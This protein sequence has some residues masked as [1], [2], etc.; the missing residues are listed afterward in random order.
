MKPKVIAEPATGDLPSVSVNWDADEYSLTCSIA[1]SDRETSMEVKT[2]S[3][4]LDRQFNICPR[5]YVMTGGS[6]SMALD[7]QLRAED[8]D[9]FTNPAQWIDCSFPYVDA[10]VSKLTFCADFDSNNRAGGIGEPTIYYECTKGTLYLAWSA[11]SAWHAV[12]V[13]LAFGVTQDGYLAQIRVDG[14]FIG[15]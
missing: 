11:A 7:T 8:L 9:I 10:P 6:F 13:P 15:K 1:Y 4:V 14:V 3:R 5:G 12:G 2:L